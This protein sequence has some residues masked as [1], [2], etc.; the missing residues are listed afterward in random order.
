[1]MNFKTEE[2]KKV[3]K[4]VRGAIEKHPYSPAFAG[5]SIAPKNNGTAEIVTVGHTVALRTVC[6]M[7][8]SSTESDAVIVPSHIFIP[9][10]MNGM[11]ETLKVSKEENTIILSCG[12][13]IAHVACIS[14]S[15]L[16]KVNFNATGGMDF[17]AGDLMSAISNVL[18]A[19]SGL[20]AQLSGACFYA[21]ES[22]VFVTATDLYRTSRAYVGEGSFNGY[23]NVPKEALQAAL[24]L[25]AFAEKDEKAHVSFDGSHVRMACA[26]CQMTSTVISGMYPVDQLKTAMNFS[27]L[28]TAK[29]HKDQI[30]SVLERIYPFAEDDRHCTVNLSLAESGMRL[31]AHSD[32]GTYEDMLECRI[33]NRPASSWEA[34]YDIRYLMDAVKHSEGEISLSFGALKSPAGITSENSVSA[35]ILPV[36]TR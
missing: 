3:L 36:R 33:E 25:L 5:V 19:A 10:V 14:D 18:F 35:M 30:R 27:P 23:V 1:M 28:F 32:I 8:Q 31:S 20:R 15:L 6:P 13:A 12:R 29:A 2:L 17:N 22:S 26:G 21:D 24:K 4:K 16:P 7:I 11:S 9:F 34:S